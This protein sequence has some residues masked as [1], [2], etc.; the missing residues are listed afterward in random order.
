[1]ITIRRA[2]RQDRDSIWRV[3]IQ[4][5]K[6][7]CKSHYTKD[8]TRVWSRLL[9]P[10][11]YEKAIDSKALFVAD[12]DDSI[13]GFGHLDLENERIEALYVSPKYVGIGVGKKILQVLERIAEQ[14]GSKIVH[15]LSTLNA[16]P[17]YE[18]AGY[19]P[20]GHSKHLLPS[21][22]VTCI[23]MAKKLSS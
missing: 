21:G 6:E 2:T 5:I 8:E 14:S 15:V 3:H 10:G 16:V 19:R 12:D 1:M 18:R 9:K 4:A 11:R 7:I 20:Q 13:V 22:L 23:L 17:F